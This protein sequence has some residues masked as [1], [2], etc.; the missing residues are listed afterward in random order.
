MSSLQQLKNRLIVSC[1]ALDEE[2]LHGPMLM[3]A[4]ARAA[5]LGGASGIRTNGAQEVEVIKKLTALPII[6]IQKIC[7]EKGEICITPTFAH[8]K[9]LVEAGADMVA[10]DCREARP[11]GEPLEELIPRI[12]KELGVSVLA[13]CQTLDD[14][15][16]ALHIGADSLAPTFGF[17]A[18]SIGIEPDFALLQ[19]MIALG[20]PVI[21]EGGYWEPAQVV[22]AFELGAWSVV[23]GSAISRPLEITK[24]FVQA[25]QNAGVG[26]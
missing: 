21:A 15:K 26:N 22:K 23:V 24:R 6:G 17:K 1:Q 7:N 20:T 9:A 5:A 4:M 25:L 2:P 13:D 3:A 12:R 16:V 18:N 19:A 14:A 10:V 8:A 11:F